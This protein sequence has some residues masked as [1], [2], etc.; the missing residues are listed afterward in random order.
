[1][2]R[3]LEKLSVRDSS[4]EPSNKRIKM[5]QKTPISQLYEECTKV[6]KYIHQL[7]FS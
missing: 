2:S 7:Q 4:G 1:M 6:S 3:K 5:A